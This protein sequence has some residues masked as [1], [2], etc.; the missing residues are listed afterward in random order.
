M[1]SALEALWYGNICPNAECREASAQAKDLMAYV[2]R[3]HNDLQATL[4]EAQKELLEKFDDCYSELCD[5]NERE[6][7]VYA[8]RLGAKIA[9][10]IMSFEAEA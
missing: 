8:F 6:T 10:E 4:T 9:F 7:F 3:H 5:I 1:K 2:T